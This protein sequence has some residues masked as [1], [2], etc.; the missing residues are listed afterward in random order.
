LIRSHGARTAAA[1]RR[2]SAL[3]RADN[4][5]VPPDT[6]QFASF[7]PSPEVLA[8]ALVAEAQHTGRDEHAERGAAR[9]SS[10][11]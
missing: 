9:T 7:E 1:S 8:A 4:P 3:G 10:R 11:A 6:R 2:A 5:R